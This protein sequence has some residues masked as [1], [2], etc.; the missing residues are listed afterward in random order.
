MQVKLIRLSACVK[1]RFQ[2]RAAWLAP[3]LGLCC[4]VGLVS[5]QDMFTWEEKFYNPKPAE[6]D[7]VL[8][9]PCGGA[10]VFR[11]VEVESDQPLDDI[12]ITV[13]NVS[14]GWGYAENPHNTYLSGAFS[15]SPNARFFLV[16]KYEVSELQYKAVTSDECPDPNMKGRLPQTRIGWF[17][18]VDF[19]HRY[20]LWVREHA[21]DVPGLPSEDGEPGFVRLPT[22][23][24]WEYAARGGA[25]V[26][27]SDFRE[28]TYPMPGGISRH[29]WYAGTASANGKAQ[30]TGLLEPNPLGL[31]DMLGNVD[32]ISM[33]LF[34][35][36]R[37]D[38]MHGQVGGYV[39]RGGN[40]FT[41]AADIRS[42]HRQEAPFYKDGEQL[43][44]KTTG[45][46][47]VISAPV[48]TS[49]GHLQRITTSWNGLGTETT[50]ASK[51]AYGELDGKTFDDPV[52]ELTA[53]AKVIEDKKIKQRITRLRDTMRATIEARNRQ[54][55]QAARESLRLGGVL[56][57]KLKDDGQAIAGL[58][59][60]YENC[61]DSRGKDHELCAKFRAKLEGEEP[62]LNYNT[63]IYAESVMGTAQNY[64]EEVLRQQ[65]ELLTD[66]LKKRE[67]EGLVQYAELYF[68]QASTYA[69][70][71]R[72]RRDDWF[73]QCA[74]EG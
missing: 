50:P 10:M 68:N 64:P 54:R 15:S 52:A 32:E 59:T 56:C 28:K 29:V 5:G 14:D 65:L 57:R 22:E 25:A 20:S 44:S 60:V 49:H 21:A 66:A 53:V 9:L 73:A 62:M 13:G 26:S 30:L 67:F 6:G 39:V 51:S 33:D 58:K 55:N 31:H 40:Y 35:L 48:I 36:N 70:N 41:P 61:T 11:P 17:D 74:G 38:R 16:G 34:R 47:V 43:R 42:S 37:L 3:L 8:P 27:P 72:V 23:D 71:W 19:S 7:V 45:F 2:S 4:H 1:S 12:Q 24:E 63:G 46:R 18:A 69:G